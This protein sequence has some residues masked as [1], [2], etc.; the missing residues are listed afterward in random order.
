MSDRDSRNDVAVLVSGGIDSAVLTLELTRQF[1]RVVPIYVRF[2]LRWERP[3]LAGLRKFL[4]MVQSPALGPLVV[5]DEP[6]ADIY[7][8]HWSLGCSGVPDQD[9]E[10]GEVSLPGRNL[11]LIAKASVWCR[12]RGVGA[13]A[14]GTLASNPFFDA[15]AGFF[16]DFETVLNRGMGEPLRLIRPFERLSKAEVMLRA[17]D[18]PL[19]ATFSC[20]DPADGLHCGACNKC[21]ERRR[22][23]RS[24]GRGD[25]TR[26]RVE[27]SPADPIHSRDGQCIE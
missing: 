26:Y 21:E 5:L 27:W 23:F 13:L 11:L 25:P 2:G 19:E 10:D 18:L 20:L 1:A 4:G 8:D 16:D 17:V 12:I 24:V 3:E 22:A 14:L 6:V 7:G 9:S 15:S